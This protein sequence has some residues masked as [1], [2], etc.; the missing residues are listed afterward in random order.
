MDRLDLRGLWESRGN[1]GSRGLAE[2]RER[3]VG[4][5]YRGLP[6]LQGTVARQG[7]S[8]R[9]AVIALHNLYI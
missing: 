1:Q 4:P 9:L 6:G 2:G 8:A 7:I 3:V 5:D